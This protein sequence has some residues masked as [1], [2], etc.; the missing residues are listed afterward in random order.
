MVLLVIHEVEMVRKNT[1]QLQ[2]HFGN[3][4]FRLILFLIDSDLFLLMTHLLKVKC[5]QQKT[6][7]CFL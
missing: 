1:L 6:R 2:G 7:F 3:L 4:A 5:I